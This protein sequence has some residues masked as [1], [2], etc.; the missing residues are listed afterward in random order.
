MCVYQHLK[1]IQI[2]LIF[3]NIY[4]KNF[5][6]KWRQRSLISASRIQCDYTSL[7]QY[8]SFVSVT[9]SDRPVPFA[10]TQSS[11]ELNNVNWGG[12]IIGKLSHT[13][14]TTTTTP[15]PHMSLYNIE[16]FHTFFYKDNFIQILCFFL[17]DF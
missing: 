10:T 15:P 1:I 11:T 16:L 5:G 9:P 7:H 3:T 13:T 17:T 12:S 14:T 8:L 6:T 4:F 2:F